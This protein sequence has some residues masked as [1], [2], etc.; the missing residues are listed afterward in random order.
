MTNQLIDAIAS[1][2]G[3]IYHEHDLRFDI[4]LITDCVI[5]CLPL[6]RPFAYDADA[7][8]K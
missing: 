3:K 1:E 8:N 4:Y 5:G 2:W 6:N 7:E